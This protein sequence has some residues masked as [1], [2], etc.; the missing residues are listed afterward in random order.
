M[1]HA[2]TV[3]AGRPA[4]VVRPRG[5]HLDEPRVRVGGEA[6]AAALFDVATFLAGA[7]P[8]LL[9]AGA[10][11]HLY[12]PKIE[13]AD[14]AA[15]WSD[16]L[17]AVETALGLEPGTVVVSVLVETVGGVVE[18]DAIVY[19][20][21]ARVTALNAGRWDYLFDFVRCAGSDAR[22]TLPE[23]GRLSMDLP[24]LVA[25]QRRIVE[26]AHRR[27]AAAIGGMA[28]AAPADGAV[29]PLSADVVRAV[30]ADK[31]RE[32]ALG[33]DGAVVAHA[34]MTDA[35]REAFATTAVE[36]AA[37]AG[38]AP[39]AHALAAH[40]PVEAILDLGD[41]WHGPLA[42]SGLR[43]AVAVATRYLDSWLGGRGLVTIAG[44]PEELSCVE[45]ARALL[46][47]W[48]QRGVALDDGTHL[49]PERFAAELAEAAGE[50]RT[51]AAALLGELVGRSELS[52]DVVP[53]AMTLIEPS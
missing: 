23:R 2:G 18:L 30:V 44:R 33:F 31:R 13:S 20:L 51:T 16:V 39:A 34:G 15:L 49:T 42:V 9:A 27:G 10:R 25:Y 35:V 28:P 41:T 36:R 11:P 45:I 8:L 12:L 32:A 3:A 26:V 14:E 50:R 46:W 1:E 53:L 52:D 48:V 5:L 24:F 21:R 38:A 22:A 17:D 4:L 40:A 19:A 37:P 43:E 47:S 29:G 6:V 7:A